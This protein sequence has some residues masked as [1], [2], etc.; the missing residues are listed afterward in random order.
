MELKPGMIVQLTV[1]R[2][3]DFGYFLTDHN[4]EIEDIL[5]HNRQVTEAIEVGQSIEVFLFHDHHGRLSATMEE[6]IISLDSNFDWLEV[7]S[8]NE[9]DGVFLYNGI[10]RDLFLSMDDLGSDRSLWPKVGEKVPVSLTFDKKGRLMGRL[11]R[12]TPVEETASVAPKTI[13]NSEITGT[14]YSFSEKGAFV[15]TEQ[16]YIAFLHF[17]ETSEELHLG[18]VLTARVTFVRD[19]G[20]INISMQPKAHERRH[21]DA[22]KIFDFLLKRD[23]GMPYTD[24]SDP[25]IIK[26]KFNMSKGSFKRALG[27]LLKEG[28][29]YQKDGWTFKKE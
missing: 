22:D 7:V 3:A 23:G 16:S 17:N 11:L 13:L 1:E 8:V 9:K 15:F 2:K 26:Q 21:D 6:P 12:G 14:V 19:D 5:L 28:K 10:S 29:I 25:I 20:K 18:K 24:K 4:K 27:K